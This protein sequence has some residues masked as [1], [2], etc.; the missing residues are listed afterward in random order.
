[1]GEAIRD[2]SSKK[3][4]HRTSS[5]HSSHHEQQNVQQDST[6]IIHSADNI[7]GQ[8]QRTNGTREV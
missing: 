3:H 4:R 5:N 1:T 6:G 8:D 7:I 2:T